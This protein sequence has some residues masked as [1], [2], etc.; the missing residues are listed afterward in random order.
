MHRKFVTLAVSVML[1]MGLSSSALAEELTGTLKKIDESGVIIMGHR[2]SS[3]PFSYYAQGKTAIGHGQDYSDLIVEA[4]KKKLNKTDLTIKYVP[5]TSQNRIPLLQNETY[6]FECGST[7]NNTERQKQVSFSNT[8]FIV[9]TRLLVAK[10]SDIKDFA[11]LKG[12]SVAV[13]SGTT[14]EKL[15]NILNDS[16]KLEVRIISTKDHGDSFRTVESG[17]AVAFMIDDVLLAGE[18]AK[19]KDPE[20]WAIIGT[21][22]SYEAYGCMMR[23]DDAQFKALVDATIAEAQLSGAAKASYEKWFLNPIPP[24]GMNMN[25]SLSDEMKALYAAPNDKAFQ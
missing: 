11:D 19:A 13:T 7:T 24:R 8:F 25:F 12:K 6:D 15:I 2:E 14:S 4:I 16:Q 1:I 18:R 5:V 3:I 23:K 9:G 17:R 10:D 21:P 22:Q 20:A